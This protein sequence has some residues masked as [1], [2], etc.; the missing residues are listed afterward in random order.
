MA[1]HKSAEK[2][3][4]QSLRRNAVNRKTRSQVRTIEK[5]IRELLVKKDKKAAEQLLNTFMSTVSKAA[6]KGVVHARQAARR[7]SRVSEQI[8]KLK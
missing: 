8:A 7:I 5:D 3:A 2:R 6:Q 4:R 1:T